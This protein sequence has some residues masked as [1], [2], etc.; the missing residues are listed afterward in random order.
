MQFDV[1]TCIHSFAWEILSFII[2]WILGD[3]NFFDFQIFSSN[4][5]SHA[6]KWLRKK[7]LLA[8]I[9]LHVLSYEYVCSNSYEVHCVLCTYMDFFYQNTSPKYLL[10][11]CILKSYFLGKRRIHLMNWV[12]S[13]RFTKWQIL[14]NP[15][16]NSCAPES[17]IVDNQYNVW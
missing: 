17:I 12:C 10:Q 8:V 5:I 2:F 15:S 16:D 14:H 4:K 7:D 1:P 6:N 13:P 3:L 9:Q 11:S